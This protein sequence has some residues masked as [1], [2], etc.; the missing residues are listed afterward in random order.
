MTTFPNQTN[1]LTVKSNT[2][3]ETVSYH[4]VNLLNE[5]S[6]HKLPTITRC[7]SNAGFFCTHGT[8]RQKKVVVEA[9]TVSVLLG[10]LQP[11]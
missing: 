6:T 10:A 11:P 8:L 7:W 2:D 5:Y 4:T 9:L 1:G 3:C